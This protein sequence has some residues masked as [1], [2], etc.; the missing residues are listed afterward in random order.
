MIA[1]RSP[2]GGSWCARAPSPISMHEDDDVAFGDMM[3]DSARGQKPVEHFTRPWC[4]PE[5]VLRFAFGGSL[6]GSVP[7]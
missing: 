1:L 4:A 6:G 5:N 3:I 2:E 7:G